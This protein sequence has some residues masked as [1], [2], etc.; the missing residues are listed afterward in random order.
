M[1]STLRH[2]SGED[3]RAK[4]WRSFALRDC[5]LNHPSA[6]SHKS[7]GILSTDE[8]QPRVQDARGALCSGETPRANRRARLTAAVTPP[9]K[10]IARR[11][12]TDPGATTLGLEILIERTI[13]ISSSM[14]R[15][16]KTAE[17]KYR[18]CP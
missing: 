2:N 4:E 18:P 11:A 16:D 8:R 14:N 7:I 17:R 10:S 6:V 5:T 9:L 12:T 1:R 15:R 13:D 3:Q